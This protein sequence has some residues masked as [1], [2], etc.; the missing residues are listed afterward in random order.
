MGRMR[1]MSAVVAGCVLL[2][3]C[4]SNN[5]DQAQDDTGGQATAAS[6]QQAG[7][8]GQSGQDGVEGRPFPGRCVHAD[9]IDTTPVTTAPRSRWMTVQDIRVPL[10]EAGPFQVNGYKQRCFSP[11]LAGA[12]AAAANIEMRQSVGNP[13]SKWAY[14]H[15]TLPVPSVSEAVDN[16]PIG[17]VELQGFR[18]DKVSDGGKKVVVFIGIE[19][20][21]KGDIVHGGV[22]DPVMWDGTDWKFD[23]KTAIA[24]D[25]DQSDGEALTGAYR[26]WKEQQ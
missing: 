7:Q 19:T 22:A 2:A 16:H 17:W 11:S 14:L 3:G 18:V 9:H 24:M 26:D 12:V 13:S 1:Q 23:S 25:K 21:Y 4:T 15:N 10:T 20:K 6:Q 5:S 8:E